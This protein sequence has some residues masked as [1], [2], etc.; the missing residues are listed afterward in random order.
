MTA[1]LW[2][3]AANIQKPKQTDASPNTVRQSVA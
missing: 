2:K 3:A 1:Y